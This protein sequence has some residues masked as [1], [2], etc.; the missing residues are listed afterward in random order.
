MT[1]FDYKTSLAG[2]AIAAMDLALIEKRYLDAIAIG[3]VAIH[4]V[5]KA[6]EL[7]QDMGELEF[8]NEPGEPE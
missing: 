6:I 8:P 2:Q 7:L 4:E 1:D 3:Q 5:N